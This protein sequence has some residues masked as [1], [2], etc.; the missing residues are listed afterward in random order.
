MTDITRLDDTTWSMVLAPPQDGIQEIRITTPESAEGSAAYQLASIIATVFQSIRPDRAV[1]KQG[2]VVES[3]A[4]GTWLVSS[5]K[6]E[7]ITAML[8]RRATT[9][10]LQW[11]PF[12]HTI[13]PS[14]IITVY[15]RN[16]SHHPCK[17]IIQKV[18][19]ATSHMDSSPPPSADIES[20]SLP[21]PTTLEEQVHAHKLFDDPFTR[22][23]ATCLQTTEKDFVMEVDHR[24]QYRFVRSENALQLRKIPS[25]PPSPA[26]Q[27]ENRAVVQWYYRFLLLEFGK[28]FVDQ[29]SLSYNIHFDEMIA[30]GLP[31][32]PDHVFKCNVGANSIELLHVEALWAAL[33][34][35][36]KEKRCL[37]LEQYA[38]LLSVRV[39]RKLL[40]R[41]ESLDNLVPYLTTRLSRYADKPFRSVPQ[42]VIH[43]II[44]L[45]WPTP[46]EQDLSMTGRKITHCAIQGCHTMGDPRIPN[47]CRDFFELEQTFQ[48]LS[49]QTRRQDYLELVSHIVTKKTLFRPTPFE[50]NSWHIGLL[51]PGPTLQGAPTWYVNDKFMNDKQGNINWGF[52]PVSRMSHDPAIIA[53]RSTASDENAFSSTDSILDDA[54][55]FGPPIMRK[56]EL[57]YPYE[58]EYVKTRTIPLWVGLLLTAQRSP[59]NQ[60]RLLGEACDEFAEYVQKNAPE[61]LPEIMPIIQKMREEKQYAALFKELQRQADEF[62]E[63][64]DD[65]Y[66]QFQDVVATGHS[67]G[68]SN[69]EFALVHFMV[70][71]KRLLLPGH[72]ACC[73]AFDPPAIGNDHD[74]EFMA[75]GRKHKEVLTTLGITFETNMQM[76]HGDPVPEGGGSHPGTTGYDKARDSWLVPHIRIFRPLETAQALSMTTLT[77]HGRRIATAREGE[78]YTLEHLTP[79]DLAEFDHSWFLRGR[80]RQLFGYRV[81]VSP[82]ISE[83]ARKTIGCIIY[84]ALC[85]RAWYDYQPFQG[86]VVALQYPQSTIIRG[87]LL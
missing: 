64:P 57:G 31:L 67:L 56:P 58:K 72:K 44:T 87:P 12:T 53:Y 59:R 79:A 62:R 34:T 18:L 1:L 66:K 17:M 25:T 29:L 52:A 24:G 68:A 36:V 54:N 5:Q 78:D 32:Y 73:F 22:L 9:W 65:K 15:T 77:T 8:F 13:S 16:I 7:W 86:D 75:Y 20:L 19:C 71:N 21:L 37:T 51:I 47:P 45:L 41:C 2:V 74:R 83:I 30:K 76:E 85:V 63:L 6:N 84:P 4:Q 50:E 26:E 39:L 35:I 33:Q 38:K 61:R 46:Q 82:R 60:E 3:S 81:L 49:N 43:E 14:K 70:H 23:A 10:I 11:I 40:E 48:D 69:S 28:S 55:P 27:E 42:E 80:V